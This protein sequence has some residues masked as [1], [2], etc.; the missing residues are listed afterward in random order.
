M[1]RYRRGES[2][3]RDEVNRDQ[4]DTGAVRAAP[5]GDATATERA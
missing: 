1:R 3:V 5:A 4:S 2:I